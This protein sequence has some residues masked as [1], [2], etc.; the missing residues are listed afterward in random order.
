MSTALGIAGV[1]AVLRDLLNDGFINHNIAGVLG[2]TITVSVLPPDRVISSNHGNNAENTQLNIFLYQVTPNQG[3][4]NNSLPSRDAA[5]R[6]RLSNPA[7][8]LNLHYLISAYSATDL[9]GD[10]LLGYAAQLLHET[11]I[12]SRE[13]IRTA[14]DPS[15][16][17][18]NNLPAALRA[19]AD[20]GLADQVEQIKITPVYLNIEELS[21]LWSATQS[22]L[23]PTVAY[24][25][26]VVLIEPKLET[27][28]PLPVLSRGPVDIS[29][30][31]DRGVVVDPTLLAPLPTIESIEPANGQASFVL[32]ETVTI[33]GH[34]LDGSSRT[35]TLHNDKY[36]I[37]ETVL[38]L[39]GNTANS[40]EFQIP[41]ADAGNFPVGIYDVR[42]NVV[43]PTEIDARTS[44]RL[45]LQLA[46]DI[47]S[48]MP[49]AATVDGF[50]TATFSV[51]FTPELRQG[52][53]ASIILGQDGY[54]PLPYTPPVSSLDFSIANAPTGNHLLRLRI[55]GY[56][57]AIIDRNADV[58]VFFNRRV[59]I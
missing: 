29:S 38:A 27:R 48:A 17:L 52:Q 5:G 45:S 11:P 54:L 43:R 21:K 28:T 55:D 12:L 44:N 2:S 13:A 53:E 10:I 31:R 51:S 40:T 8:A 50:G 49:I 23:R 56:D 16:T 6:T 24:E 47:T 3:W 22:S 36:G 35:V 18:S 26:S 20:C 39:P 41:V 4:R 57:S 7:L 59:T 33:H 42:I 34:H 15:P 19:L 37:E 14:L 1:T 46:P 30:G 58:P 32:G 9:H 25:V